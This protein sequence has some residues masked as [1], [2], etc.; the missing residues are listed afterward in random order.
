MCPP[1][2]SQVY[3]YRVSGPSIV[4][5]AA[6]QQQ[7]QQQTSPKLSARTSSATPS[8]MP[9]VPLYSLR[10]LPRSSSALSPPIIFCVRGGNVPAAGSA[11]DFAA[12]RSL[13]APDNAPLLCENCDCMGMFV[14]ETGACGSVCSMVRITVSIIC[15]GWLLPVAPQQSAL[16]VAA[17]DVFYLSMK[18]VPFK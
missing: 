6:Q 16:R 12:A 3:N 14:M 17:G 1:G 13:V 5:V 8:L 15:S 10:A 18:N 2:D 9:A 11:V 4:G 7:Q